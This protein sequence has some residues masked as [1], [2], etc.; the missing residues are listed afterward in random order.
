MC[1]YMCMSVG[2]GQAGLGQP[3]LTAW[4]NMSQKGGLKDGPVG[5]HRLY[6]IRTSKGGKQVQVGGFYP[7]R[8]STPKNCQVNYFQL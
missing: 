5:R 7:L 6:V 8:L 4:E 1:V 3:P 2:E